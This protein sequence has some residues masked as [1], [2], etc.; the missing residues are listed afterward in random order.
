METAITPPLRIQPARSTQ[1]SAKT[2]HVRV[3]QF[4]ADFHAR[5]ILART[6]GD[7]AVT[8]QLSK[9]ADALRQEHRMKK[10]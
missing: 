4:L 10:Q 3:N 5:N 9:L 2:A 6:Q 7:A 8:A 1:I